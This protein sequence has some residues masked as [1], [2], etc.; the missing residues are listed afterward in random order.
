MMLGIDD[1]CEK[2]LEVLSTVPKS[3]AQIT[4]EV[5]AASTKSIKQHLT[6]L[7]EKGLVNIKKEKV[8]LRYYY[9]ITISNKGIDY[10]KIKAHDK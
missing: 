6:H 7:D 4:R 2:I 5:G 1:V 3:L 8:G 9:Q 10:K